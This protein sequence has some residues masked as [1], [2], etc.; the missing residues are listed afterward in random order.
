MKQLYTIE[1]MHCASCASI[2]TKKLGNFPGVESCEVNFAL[3]NATIDTNLSE[4]E[5][6]TELQKYWYSLAAQEKKEE[7]TEVMSE[8][9]MN[10]T[11]HASSDK[12]DTSLENAWR[13]VQISLVCIVPAVMIMI[14]MI[15]ADYGFWNKNAVVA[16]VFHHILP[17]LATIMLFLVGWKYIVAIGRYIRYGVANMDTLVGI[18]T[19]TAFLYSFIISAFE[20]PLAPYLDVERGFYEA[21]IV[22]IGFIEIGKYMEMKVMSKTGKAIEALVGLQA[23]EALIE[24][25][26]WVKV[27][28]LSQVKKGDI[29]LVKAGEKIPL[30]GVV[31]SGK[32]HIDESM[33]TG[34]P[35]PVNKETGDVVIG[36]TLVTD[37]TL[38]IE[39][40]AVGEETYL[41]KIIAI[42]SEAQNSKPEIQK[43]ADGIMR[44][45]VPGVLIIATLAA[46][47][48]YFLG[49][50]FFPDIPA[51][52][53]AVMS[54]VGVLVIACPCGLGLATPMAIITGVGHGAKNGI[55]AKNAQGL[56][57][58][59]K[60]KY[61]IFD[62]T[63]T[64][65]EG[66]PT[67]T[68]IHTLSGDQ[69]NNVE[70]LVSLESL[71]S[72]PIAHALTIYG[73]QKNISLKEVE[74]FKNLE[75]VGIQGK[76]E[77][78]LYIISKPS[79]LEALGFSGDNEVVETW[80]KEGKTPLVLSNSKGVLGY[81]AVAD[82]LK[83][84][85]LEAIE[86]LKKMGITPV[87]LT[88]DHQ[89]TAHFIA[90]KLGIEEVYAQVKPEEK[91]QIVKKFQSKG[92][93]TMV[94]D[95]INDAPAL[96]SADIG[97][98]MSTGTDVAIE[99]ADITL[100]HGDL[101][102]L[103]LAIR[104]SKLTQ[105]AIL[106]NLAWAFGFNLIGIPLAAGVFYPLLGVLLN[107]AF[108]GA[109]MA[110]SDLT[111]VG[112]SLRLQ[113]KKITG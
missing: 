77:G 6:N 70:I 59:R 49:N 75:W 54:F 8:N 64:L 43:I 28:P 62:K 23:K 109:A 50:T 34:E 7:N 51:L 63:G 90:E 65:T 98:A 67:L 76:I 13:K 80:T 83:E 1:G 66:K 53:F 31:L 26:E 36:S 78:E 14:W 73:Q 2:I 17:I 57:E 96:A 103:V 52:Q 102:K 16:G 29:M 5:L 42:V 81:F 37:S 69:Q 86:S 40:Q 33:I 88:G 91:A 32:A 71:S 60:T 10:H 21:V 79:H 27:V 22:V 12:K 95:G 15:G 3:K 35:L 20:W 89:N 19:V 38:R 68:D 87:M 47:F 72:H 100:L 92:I 39:A 11:Q 112:N 55:L 97:V 58:L 41:A 56:L 46:L 101:K 85:S 25:K 4:Q 94:G 110:F 44:F 48:W 24:S 104:I 74:D 45:F 18:G 9:H 82:A 113:R 93:T 105:S 30:D 61:V 107:P 106:Q 108:E 111:V 84:T 99:S